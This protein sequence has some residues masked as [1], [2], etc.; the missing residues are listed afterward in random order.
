MLAS[1]LGFEFCVS[2]VETSFES[3]RR[4]GDCFPLPCGAVRDIALEAGCVESQRAFWAAEALNKLALQGPLHRENSDRLVLTSG[5]PLTAVQSCAAD[6]IAQS[7]LMHGECPDDLSPAR[8]LD[9]L[10]G[11]KPSYDGIPNNLASFSEEKLKILRSRIQPKAIRQ[12]LPAEAAKLLEHAATN[13]EQPS[14]SVFEPFTPYWDPSLRHNPGK[15]LSFILKLFQSGLLVLRRRPKSHVGV[16]FVK[17]KTPDAIRMV[18][19]CR[20]ANKKHQPPPLSRL[21]SARTYCDLDL[22]TSG[23]QEDGAYGWAR[24][25]DVNDCFYR[26]GVPE[27]AHYFAIDHPLSAAEWSRLGIESKVVFDHD[28]K[29]DCR[30]DEHELL[31]PCFQAVPMGWSWAL[32]F[33]HEAVLE[34]AQ[35]HKPWEDG[36]LREKKVTPQLYEYRT[37]LGVYVDNITVLGKNKLDVQERCKALDLAFREA[38]IPITWSQDEPVTRLDSVGCH[39]DLE[40]GVLKNKSSRVWKFVRATEALLRRKKLSGHILQIW[41]GHFTS[42]CSVTPWGL[43]CLQRV[44]RF[45]ELAGVGRKVVWSSVRQEL[46]L[47]SA[48]AWMTWRSLAA[49]FSEVVDVGD[50]ATSGY[51][52]MSCLPPIDFIKQSVRVHEKWRFLPMPEALRNPANA[53]DHIA[54]EE[55]LGSLMASPTIV[56]LIQIVSEILH[57]DPPGLTLSMLE[58]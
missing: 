28:V 4:H 7:L 10:R 17:K 55:A 41:T 43:S 22:S 31:W 18:I 44:Y 8:A 52:M 26:F 38:D 9:Q 5:R 33:C 2:M 3:R 36:I 27:L 12:F 32:F 54:F 49:P 30:T 51:A 40:A 48:L 53:G 34:I 23:L 58:W 50:S 45:I 6:R 57:S 29:Y 46:K 20:G 37:I 19:D 14:G 56:Q 25:T 39:L 24:E 35:R 15:R 42:L 11:G 16:F 21:G 1:A 47:A 13:I